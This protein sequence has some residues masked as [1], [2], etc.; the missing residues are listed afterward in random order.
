ML[1]VDDHKQRAEEGEQTAHMPEPPRPVPQYGETE[2]D[3]GDSEEQRHEEECTLLAIAEHG[4][5]VVREHSQR[6]EVPDA[7][8]HINSDSQRR[9]RAITP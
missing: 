3:A 6:D 2:R 1:S 8:D 5:A 9:E 4:L 7:S